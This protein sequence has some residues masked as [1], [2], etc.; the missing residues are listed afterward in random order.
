MPIA[1]ALA[2][3][4]SLNSFGMVSRLANGGVQRGA[5]LGGGAAVLAA[6]SL[7]SRREAPAAPATAPAPWRDA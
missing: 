3:G 2:G 5:I 7:M 1:A 4:M 6:K